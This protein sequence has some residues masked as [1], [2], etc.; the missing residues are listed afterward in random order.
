MEPIKSNQLLNQS[1]PLDLAEIKSQP[2]KLTKITSRMTVQSSF[3]SFSKLVVTSTFFCPSSPQLNLPIIM[4]SGMNSVEEV[5]LYNVELTK[6]PNLKEISFSPTNILQLSVFHP[7]LISLR[8]STQPPVTK[9]TPPF[10]HQKIW[11]PLLLHVHI[12]F[13]L[14]S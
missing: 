8:T 3:L 11:R 2:L 5:L 6:S 12:F 13:V 10:S 1:I 9:P 14:S 7:L 4:G